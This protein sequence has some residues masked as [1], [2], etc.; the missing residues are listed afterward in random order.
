MNWNV[1]ITLRGQC[2]FFYSQKTWNSSFISDFRD[3]NNRIKRKSFP[4]PKIQD[5]LLKYDGFKYATSL[6][7]NMGL[8]IKKCPFSWKI[9]TIVLF[10]I[11]YAYKKLPVGLC[12]SPD[13]F[14]EKMNE[15]FNCLEYI[16]TYIDDL[17][18]I[19]DKSLKI[20]LIN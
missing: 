14:Q 16:K 12:N 4:I 11:K 20:T 6:D 10:W 3:L 13:M 9:C 18:I 15:L 1:K 2:L 8:H 5:L 17:F 19:S 7:L